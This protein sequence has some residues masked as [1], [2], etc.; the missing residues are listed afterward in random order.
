M[1]NARR[2]CLDCDWASRVFDVQNGADFEEFAQAGNFHA[3]GAKHYVKLVL[4]G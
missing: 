4:K 1:T 2:V 3:E